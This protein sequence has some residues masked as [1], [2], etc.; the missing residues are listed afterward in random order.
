MKDT[1]RGLWA[2][3]IVEQIERFMGNLGNFHG[4][5]SENWTAK[6]LIW[7]RNY[8]MNCNGKNGKD[9]FPQNY[10]G[11]MK[12]RELLRISDEVIYFACDEK[13]CRHVARW[14]LIGEWKGTNETVVL[15]VCE[16]HRAVWE[17]CLNPDLQK[18]YLLTPKHLTLFPFTKLREQGYEL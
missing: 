2:I 1:H 4:K 13:G 18:F 8:V 10:K 16:D 9:H 3:Y 5:I 7:R 15:N 17:D 6:Q 12:M 11:G 14:R